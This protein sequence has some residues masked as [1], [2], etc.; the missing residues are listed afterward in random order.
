MPSQAIWLILL[1]PI[2]S[3]LVISLLVKPF[4]KKESKLGSYVAIAAIG[5]SLILSLWTLF[6]TMGASHHEIEMHSIPWLTIGNFNVAVGGK[7]VHVDDI[8][9]GHCQ[10]AF[11]SNPV[12]VFV[13]KTFVFGGIGGGE[14]GAPAFGV[15]DIGI[16]NTGFKIIHNFKGALVFFSVF[17]GLV[18]KFG[19]KFEFWRMNQADVHSV[20]G[21]QQ[22]QAVG[23]ALGF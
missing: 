21:H 8:V 4:A 11:V 1:L 6:E 20:A 7:G 17:L 14:H 16:G 12:A 13:G 3:F 15:P 22:N 2:I 5:T 23:H 18:K 9:F 10:A 19:F